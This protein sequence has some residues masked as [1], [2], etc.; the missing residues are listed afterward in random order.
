MESGDKLRKGEKG[1]ELIEHGGGVFSDNF[2][3]IDH[4]RVW[5]T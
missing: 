4:Y 1:A 5:D 2:K 3:E